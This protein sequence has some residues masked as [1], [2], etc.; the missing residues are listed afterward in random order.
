MKDLFLLSG[1]GADKR[2]FDF[3]DLGHFRVQHLVWEKPL[4]KEELNHYARR[5]AAQITVKKPILIGLSFGGLMAMEL[6]K[7]IPTEKIIIISSIKSPDQLSTKNRF[8]SRLGIHHWIPDFLLTKPN[9]LLFKIFGLESQ[10]EEDLLSKILEDTDPD[11]LRWGF[12]QI[13]RWKNENCPQVI[14]IHGGKDR[15]FSH[16]EGDYCVPDGGHFMIVNRAREISTILK[17]VLSE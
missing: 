16:Q 3:L 14:Q 1:M 5:I 8:L 10:G 2:A 7:I 11:F 15:I 6:G 4:K 13:G 12:D 17:K 9:R